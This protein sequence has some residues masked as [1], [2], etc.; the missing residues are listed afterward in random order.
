MEKTVACATAL[1]LMIASVTTAGFAAE[2][3]KVSRL[4]ALAE[5]PTDP[6]NREL[7]EETKRR[8]GQ[9]LN[10]HRTLGHAPQ[11]AKAMRGMTYALRYDSIRHGCCVR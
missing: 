3:G 8:G 2:G 4:P 10:L 5:P 6:I 9:I 7:F 11:I 1:A